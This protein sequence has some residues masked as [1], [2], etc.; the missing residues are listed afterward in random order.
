MNR[1][2]CGEP[3]AVCVRPTFS[4]I[5]QSPVAARAGGHFDR[6]RG[7]AT[8]GCGALSRERCARSRSET[9]TCPQQQQRGVLQSVRG[10]EKPAWLPCGPLAL[11]ARLCA[12]NTPAHVHA[13]TVVA[14]T[15]SSILAQFCWRHSSMQSRRSASVSST[16]CH[17]SMLQGPCHVSLS[18]ATCHRGWH[19]LCH[20]VYMRHV[21]ARPADASAD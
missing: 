17:A 12:S 16:T 15:L 8:E 7:T 13:R 21:V 3:A 2:R 19:M 6:A 20:D 18:Y 9:P 1:A 14:A 10:I 11:L 5:V 4:A